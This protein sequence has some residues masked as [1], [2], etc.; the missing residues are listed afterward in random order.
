MLLRLEMRR[1]EHISRQPA[2][3]PISKNSRDVEILV[4]PKLR[5]AC[6][7]TQKKHPTYIITA[8]GNPR[9]PP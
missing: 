4:T 3:K 1:H 2:D 9:S 6:D 8:S 7:A 5:A